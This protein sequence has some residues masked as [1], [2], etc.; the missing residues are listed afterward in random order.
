M[1]LLKAVFVKIKMLLKALENTDLWQ[2][3]T[4][5]FITDVAQIGDLLGWLLSIIIITL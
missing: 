4:V 3:Q 1:H 5:Y 2:N